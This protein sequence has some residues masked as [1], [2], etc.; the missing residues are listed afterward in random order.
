VSRI[1][2]VCVVLVAGL[3]TLVLQLRHEPLGDMGW[4][5]R[6][7][8]WRHEGGAAPTVPAQA[9]EPAASVQSPAPEHPSR[10]ISAD[11]MPDRTANSA[12]MPVGPVPST[13]GKGST[14][15]D[16]GKV[17]NTASVG[18]GATDPTSVIGRPFPVSA[19]VAAGCKVYTCPETDE[20]LA[21]FAREPQDPAWSAQMEAK[22][23]NYVESQP[24]QYKIR[25]IECRTTLCFIEV[26]SPYGTI[27]IPPYNY[28]LE[29]WLFPGVPEVGFEHNVSLGKI[30]VSLMP[31]V[32]QSR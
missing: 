2:A 9:L 5:D 7:G 31:F 10:P 22:L 8:P 28:P 6:S 32:R 15:I 14:Q 26:A 23:Q 24:G 27:P 19:S 29:E 18:A 21:R 13:D 25:A 17:P 12:I 20:A 16:G 30:T 1:V 4:L 11:V 3:I